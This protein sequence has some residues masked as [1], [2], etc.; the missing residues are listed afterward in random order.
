MG[1]NNMNFI[2]QIIEFQLFG[3]IFCCFSQ[4]LRPSIG[5]AEKYGMNTCTLIFLDR[6]KLSGSTTT[7]ESKPESKSSPDDNNRHKQET[8]KTKASKFLIQFHEMIH[9]I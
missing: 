2:Y 7:R 9:A 1:T 3:H 8:H 4:H 5:V 6:V